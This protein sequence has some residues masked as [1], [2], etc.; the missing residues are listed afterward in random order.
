MDLQSKV[1]AARDSLLT[2]LEYNKQKGEES[3]NS[4]EDPNKDNQQERGKEEKKGGEGQ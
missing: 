2:V 4:K 3:S 1:F